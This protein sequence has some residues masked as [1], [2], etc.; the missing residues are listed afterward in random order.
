MNKGWFCVLMLSMIV[1]KTAWSQSVDADFSIPTEACRNEPVNI[2]NNSSDADRYEWDFCE[3]DLKSTTSG[4]L[5]TTVNGSIT[6]GV[7]LIHDGEKYF[8]FVTSRETNSI[9]RLDFG[10]DLQSTPSVVDLGNIGNISPWRPIDIEIVPDGNQWHAFVYGESANLIT[11]LDFGESLEADADDITAEVILTGQGDSNCGL[12]VYTIADKKIIAYSKSYGIGTVEL[13]NITDV[14]SSGMKFY[15]G[16][17]SGVQNLGDVKLAF[18]N[19]NWFLYAP[20]FGPQSLLRFSFGTTILSSP[21]LTDISGSFI[22]N[23]SPFGIDLGFDNGTNVLF[24]CTIEG[25]LIRID[26]GSD[27]SALPVSGERLGN[28]GLLSN[29]LK[30]SLLKVK[31]VWTGAS[32]SYNAGQVFRI[33]FAQPACSASLTTS[34][35]PHPSVSFSES[36]TRYISLKAFED[37]SFSEIHKAISISGSTAPNL[38]IYSSGVCAGNAVQFKVG[39]N[40]SLSATQ[41]AFGDGNNAVGITVDHTFNAAGSYTISLNAVALNGCENT[42]SLPLTIYNAPVADFTAPAGLVCT[43]NELLFQ[44]STADNFDGLLAYKWNVDNVQVGVG[45]DLNYAF[46]SD[47]N[48]TVKLIAHI[49]GCSSE[50]IEAVADVKT[51]PVSSFDVNGSCEKQDVFFDNQSTGAIASYKWFVDGTIAGTEQDLTKSFDAGT[52]AIRLQTVGTNGCETSHIKNILINPKAQPDFEILTANLCSG[53]PVQ[54]KQLTQ[55]PSGASVQQYKWAFGDG[56]ES[57]SADVQHVYVNP[58]TYAVKLTATTSAGCSQSV[59]KMLTVKPSPSTEFTVSTV[60]ASVPVTLNSVEDNANSWLWTMGEKLYQVRNPV[61]TFRNAGSHNVTLKITGK[62]GCESTKTRALIVPQVLIPQFTV[63]KNCVNEETIFE[64]VTEGDDPVVLSQWMF[65]ADVNLTGDVVKYAWSEPG[66]KSVKLTVTSQSGCTYMREQSVIIQH[67][68]VASFTSTPE[69]GSPPAEISFTNLSDNI[70]LNHW[71]FGD[72]GF[73]DETSPTHIFTT[74][75]VFSVVLNAS[76]EAGCD[77]SFSADITISAPA[78]N[79]EVVAITSAD[80]PD[81]SLNILVTIENKGNTVLENLP[82]DIDISG[83]ITLSERIDERILPLS[84]YNFVLPYALRRSEDLQFICASVRL[85]DDTEEEGN[86]NCVEFGRSLLFMPGYPNPASNFITVEWIGKEDEGV[87]IR[88]INA[89]GRTIRQ[90][91]ISSHAGFNTETVDVQDM[92]KG[93][94]LLVLEGKNV[95]TTQHI[96]LSH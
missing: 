47:G 21:T 45:E 46:S 91:H 90:Y 51:G 41:W 10:G 40:T 36:G 17:I 68:V 83:D 25:P 7:E 13:T 61:H 32:I 66:E 29:T 19:G 8:A 74:E 33:N 26:L 67:P 23:V 38:T 54:L 43:N 62:N 35:A 96:V 14:P 87:S 28:F 50:K 5:I 16:N 49:P 75:G 63:L 86:R 60:C 4:S 30:F 64:D 1:Y 93:V 27:L 6:A 72:G 59:Q 53:A 80:N 34:E 77:D 11:R 39:T 69:I 81:G 94:Y 85:Q 22:G 15:S 56:S 65:G 92:E 18:A 76:N 88:L 37:N 79:A 84:R 78:P 71:S 24:L 95:K 3:G 48:H 9:L 89:M 82:L 70:S 12:D 58:G 20:T 2:V 44:N 31:S 42:I 57:I 52:Y 55:I 73:S